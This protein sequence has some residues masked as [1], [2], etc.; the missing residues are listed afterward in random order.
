MELISI[1][2]TVH[3]IGF[4]RAHFQGIWSLKLVSNIRKYPGHHSYDQQ[5]GYREEGHDEGQ[6]AGRK[7]LRG[8]RTAAML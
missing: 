6:Q 4:S 5:R 8:T 7:V 3:W 1:A 2:S